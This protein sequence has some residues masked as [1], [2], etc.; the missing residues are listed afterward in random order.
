MNIFKALRNNLV[1][2]KQTMQG[3]YLELLNRADDP[4]EGDAERLEAVINELGITIEQAQ[5][6]AA[7]IAEV[8]Q[9]K[10][11]AAE[12]E[13]RQKESGIAARAAAAYAQETDALFIQRRDEYIALDDAHRRA[14]TKCNESYK[15]IERLDEI[16]A[17]YP[18]LLS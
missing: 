14:G 15:A 11:I 17:K 2:K 18:H 12:S 10:P 7:I 6:D 9:L 8:K 4:K 16:R 5:T 3:L 1:E 13:T